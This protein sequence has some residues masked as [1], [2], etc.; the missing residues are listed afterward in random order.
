M[1]ILLLLMTLSHDCGK[2]FFSLLAGYFVILANFQDDNLIHKRKFFTLANGNWMILKL[3]AWKSFKSEYCKTVS[4]KLNQNFLLL[5]IRD[6]FSKVHFRPVCRALNSTI[7]GSIS[8]SI[9][10][11]KDDSS[12]FCSLCLARLIGAVGANNPL[13]L[14]CRV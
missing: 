4:S 10:S 14:A 5:T 13:T 9:L 6:F 2:W 3:L 8:S 12:I 1:A 7:I 11:L